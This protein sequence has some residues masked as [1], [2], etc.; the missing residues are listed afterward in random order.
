MNVAA[1]IAI[2][3]ACET[4]T[5]GSMSRIIVRAAQFGATRRPA[6]RI[7][8]ASSSTSA[9]ARGP[10]PGRPMSAAR[11]PSASIK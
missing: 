9:F 2:P 4:S 7:S 1:S 5:I 6:L 3:V 10:A 8:R 11:M